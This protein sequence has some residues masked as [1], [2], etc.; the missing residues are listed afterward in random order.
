M[1]KVSALKTGK[2]MEQREMQQLVDEL[3]ACLS[4]N[5]SLGGKAV[6]VNLGLADI[7]KSFN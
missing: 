1:A 5:I 3:F 2:K 6:I 7:D 4:P